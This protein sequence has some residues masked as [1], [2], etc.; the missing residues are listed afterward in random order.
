MGSQVI[1]GM[2][3]LP[4]KLQLTTPFRSPLKAKHGTDRRTENGHQCNMLPPY[5]AG[6]NE[7]STHIFYPIVIQTT[8]TRGDLVIAS[9]SRR[10]SDAPQSSS[11]TPKFSTV[12]DRKSFAVSTPVHGLQRGFPFFRFLFP[13]AFRFSLFRF[14]FSISVHFH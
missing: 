5:G 8:G 11:R 1:R 10:L 12:F 4:P 2:E 6:H 14:P 3:F 9:P 13:N 7:A